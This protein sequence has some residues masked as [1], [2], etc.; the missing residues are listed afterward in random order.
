MRLSLG[1]VL[2]LT[3]PFMGCTETSGTAG[4]AGDGGE[5]GAGGVGGGG[6]TAGAGGGLVPCQP[7]TDRCH[8][9]TID[10]HEPCCEQPVPDQD[11]ACDGSESTENPASCTPTG[12]PITYRL[13]VMEVEDDCNVG[14][15]LDGCNGESCVPSGLAPAEG[16]SGVDNALAGFAPTAEGV[17]GNLK[18]LNKELSDALCGLAGGRTC[19]GGDDAGEFC[20]RDEE[21]RGVDARCVSADCRVEIATT[22]IRFVID[23]NPME[24]C[25][26]LT[27]LTDGEPSAHFLN[28]SDDGCLSGRLGTIPLPLVGWTYSLDNTVVRTTVSPAGFSH[29]RLG[30]T[31]DGATMSEVIG[32]FL[33][34]AVA[35][36]VLDINASTPPT[37]DAAAACNGLSATFR[38]GGMAESL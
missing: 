15:D 37:I 29:G 8:N 31:M 25:A 16:M 2:A 13:T 19:E 33:V 30:G 4:S 36:I 35:T 3:F 14:Y 18:A 21:C 17:G 20:A 9:G 7:T 12:N 32:T 10:P 28:L 11:N 26:N 5:A 1:L 34:G 6:G 24:G 38:I 23:A 22:Q 27:V